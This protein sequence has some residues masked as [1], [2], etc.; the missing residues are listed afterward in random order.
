MKKH[1]LKNIQ[2]MEL[3]LLLKWNMTEYPYFLCINVVFKRSKFFVFFIKI[4]GVQSLHFIF[5]FIMS[6]DFI[7]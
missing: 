3:G 4:F 1:T 7:W 6:A 5:K 2:K